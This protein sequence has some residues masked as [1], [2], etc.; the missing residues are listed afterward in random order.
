[1]RGNF[2]YPW[3]DYIKAQISLKSLNA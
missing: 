3:V 1:M 2:V